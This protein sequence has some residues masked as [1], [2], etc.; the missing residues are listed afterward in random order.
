MSTIQ[1]DK[2]Q[3]HL[4]IGIPSKRKSK[5]VESPFPL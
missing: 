5:G 2:L 1:I 3:K 4:V